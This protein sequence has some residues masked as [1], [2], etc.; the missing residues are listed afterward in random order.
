[1][2]PDS[3]HAGSSPTLTDTSSGILIIPC[4]VNI[5]IPKLYLITITNQAQSR[6][7]Q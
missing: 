6:N 2:Q 1:M 5:C 7:G 4:H 3:P